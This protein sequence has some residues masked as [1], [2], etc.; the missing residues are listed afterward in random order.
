MTLQF[1]GTDYTQGFHRPLPDPVNTDEPIVPNTIYSNLDK[2]FSVFKS[3]VD[4]SVLYRKMFNDPTVK[5]SCF[6]FPDALLSSTVK[7]ALFSL[8]RDDATS[9]L[10]THVIEM[11]KRYDELMTGVV[12]RTRRR[13]SSLAFNGG[14]ITLPYESSIQ[15]IKILS[16]ENTFRNGYV[17]VINQPII[18]TS[19]D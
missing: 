5:I 11:Q 15:M 7:K 16:K 18:V 6:V 13:L 10:D 9:L 14:M 12:L 1:W 19:R 8:D 4:K 3:L 17:F 2:S